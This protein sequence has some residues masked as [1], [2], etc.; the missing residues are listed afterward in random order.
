[1]KTA[2]TG[3]VITPNYSRGFTYSWSISGDFNDPGPWTFTV[4]EGP[5]P[6]GPWRIISPELKNAYGWKEDAREPVG[7]ANV[8]YFRIELTTSKG[9]YSSPVIQPYGTLSRRDFLV[10]REIMR[11]SVLHSKGMA[12]TECKAYIRSTFG[13][14]CTV[15]LDPITGE[16]RD[17]HC[18]ACLGTGRAPAFHGPYFLFLNFSEDNQHQTSNEKTGTVEKKTFTAQAIGNPALKQGDAIVV[19]ASDKRYYVAAVAVAAEMRRI[20]IIQTLALEEAPLTDK[21]YD[22]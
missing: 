19:P 6:D 5:A 16:I 21:I 11:Q 22:L 3:F 15:C 8:L 18:Q 4:Q 13:P 20:P 1:M 12:G 9:T 17:S 10:A 2:F 14:R 7:K